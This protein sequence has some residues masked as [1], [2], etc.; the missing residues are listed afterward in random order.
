MFNLIDKNKWCFCPQVETLRHILFE[1]NNIYKIYERRFLSAL[2]INHLP[3]D[4]TRELQWMI[5]ESNRKEAKIKV[6]KL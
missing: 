3:G 6:I 5:K 2:Q 4:W 1:Y